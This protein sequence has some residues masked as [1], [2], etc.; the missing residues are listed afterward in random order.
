MHEEKGLDTLVYPPTAILK[1]YVHPCMWDFD[2]GGPT[3]APCIYGFTPAVGA[4]RITLEYV[5]LW[6]IP[7]VQH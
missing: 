2:R 4:N 7:A 3:C 1:S 6:A 5:P